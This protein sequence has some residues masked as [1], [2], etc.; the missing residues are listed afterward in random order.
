M[1]KGT[2]ETPRSSRTRFFGLMRPKFLGHQSRHFVWQPQ[3]IAHHHKHTISTLKHDGG[4]IMLW[5]CFSAAALEALERQRVKWVQQNIW[6]SWRTIWF[7][8]QVNYDLG[9]DLFSSKTMTRG[10]YTLSLCKLTELEQSYKE[11]WSKIAV[12]RYASLIDLSTQAQC[13]DCGQRCILN[14]DFK[15]VNICAVPCFT[16]YIL[17]KWH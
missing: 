15:G 16:L 3:N 6:K 5:G 9:E 2:W 8:L 11:D 12:S 4:R 10:C 1:P 17:V 13:C 7:S 14:S